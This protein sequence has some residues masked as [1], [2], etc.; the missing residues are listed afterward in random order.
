MIRV[1]RIS[2]FL[3]FNDLVCN[4]SFVCCILWTVEIEES[5]APEGATLIAIGAPPSASN[6]NQFQHSSTYRHHSHDALLDYSPPPPYSL[7]RAQQQAQLQPLYP[8]QPRN[9]NRNH[10]AEAQN[11]TA[12][13][14]MGEKDQSGSLLYDDSGQPLRKQHSTSQCNVFV[15]K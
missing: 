6:S 7:Q 2:M 13:Q 12:L 10:D 15:A 1:V 9:L 11:L 3:I 8:N 5:G 14:L 4:A